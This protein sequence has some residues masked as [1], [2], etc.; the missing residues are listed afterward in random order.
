MKHKLFGAKLTG[1]LIVEVGLIIRF[2]CIALYLFGS[3]CTVPLALRLAC[4]LEEAPK[5]LLASYP[6]FI[7]IF[8]IFFGF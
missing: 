4:F 7:I 8:F 5:E 6:F 1:L 3:G 2:F